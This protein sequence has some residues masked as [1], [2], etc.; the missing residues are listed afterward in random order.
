M[1]SQAVK[2]RGVMKGVNNTRAPLRN[3]WYMPEAGGH[4]PARCIYKAARFIK[5]F[6]YMVAL[7]V[8][9]KQYTLT[10]V[11]HRTDVHKCPRTFKTFFMLRRLK[12]NAPGS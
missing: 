4:I 12:R 7:T 6:N 11:G 8:F 1:I 9:K 2:V 3:N 5:A 10:R